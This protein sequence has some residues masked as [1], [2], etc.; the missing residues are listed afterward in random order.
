MGGW[1][2]GGVEETAGEEGLKTV[3][4]EPGSAP[5]CQVSE[6]VVGRAMK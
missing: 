2:V 1:A 6:V 5:S 4:T 3:G